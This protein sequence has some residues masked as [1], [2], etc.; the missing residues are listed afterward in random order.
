MQRHFG[1][2]PPS[3]HQMILTL[4][5]SGFIRRQ[6]GV[7]AASRCSFLPRTYPSC[8]VKSNPPNLCDDVLMP[9][10]GVPK[11]H[12]GYNLRKAVGKISSCF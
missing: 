2:T 11:P 1:V 6:A 7:P 5:R 3:V 10:P 9:S 4:E 8:K 12:F